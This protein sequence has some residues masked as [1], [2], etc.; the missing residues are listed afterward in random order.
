MLELNTARLARPIFWPGRYHEISRPDL[1]LEAV[2]TFLAELAATDDT[3]LTLAGVGD[4]L[5]APAWLDVI[6]AARAA[7]LAVHVETDLLGPDESA[8]RRLAESDA[9]VVSVHLPAVTPGTYEAVMGTPGYERVL[10]HVRLFVATRAARGRGTPLLVPVFTKCKANLAEMEAWYDA[11]LRA[12]GCATITG[13]SD[14]AGQI[15]D[16]SVADMSP[17]LRRACARLNSRLTVLSDGRIVS[18]EQDVLG[19]HS[20][21]QI[22]RYSLAEVW[23]QRFGALRR[24]PPRRMERPAAL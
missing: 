19:R 6:A 10:E 15:P 11:W 18:C 22:G 5:L 17:P 9:D 2:E 20:L 3:R 1:S 4:P 12:L 24:P 13:P 16:A 23:R 8:V 21:G 14:C 7:G